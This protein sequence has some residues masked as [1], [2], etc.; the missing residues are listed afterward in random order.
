MPSTIFLPKG[1]P[2]GLDEVYFRKKNRREYTFFFYKQS[3][4]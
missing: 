2:K 4:I 1:T 3:K